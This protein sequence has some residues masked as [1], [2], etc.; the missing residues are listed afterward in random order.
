[1]NLSSDNY[2]SQAFETGILGP[3]C[4]TAHCVYLSNNDIRLLAETSTS[5]S[6]NA[7]SNEKLYQRSKNTLNNILKALLDFLPIHNLLNSPRIAW[8][9]SA[10]SW[11]AEWGTFAKLQQSMNMKR[12][13]RVDVLPWFYIASSFYLYFVKAS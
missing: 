1:M 6:H 3:I 8:D 13:L 9:T 10:V 12:E 11:E 5:I 4:V 2:S 7:D